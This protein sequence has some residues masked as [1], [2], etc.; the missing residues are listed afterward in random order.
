MVPTIFRVGV[1][2]VRWAPQVLLTW[3][4]YYAATG[5]THFRL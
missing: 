4:N 5:R 2:L 3:M 1:A